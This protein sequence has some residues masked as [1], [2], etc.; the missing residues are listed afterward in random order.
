ME[1]EE[2]KLTKNQKFILEVVVISAIV[3]IIVAFVGTWL[4]YEV[5]PCYGDN[6]TI[7]I[8]NRFDYPKLTCKE[9]CRFFSEKE[10]I[11]MTDEKSDDWDLRWQK[12]LTG[13]TIA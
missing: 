12:N 10:G 3:G 5:C 9:Q 7:Y 2:I 8:T 13:M 1:E 11:K 6:N 4:F